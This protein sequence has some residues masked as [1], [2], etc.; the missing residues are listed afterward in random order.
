MKEYSRTAGKYLKISLLFIVSF[1]I[2]L[3]Y[4]SFFIA[5]DEADDEANSDARKNDPP[6]LEEDPWVDSVFSTMTPDQ[7]LGQLFMIAARS[8]K[9]NEYV[10]EIAETI[11]K[12]NIGGLIFMQGT[13]QRQVRHTNYYRSVAKVPLLIAMDAECGPAMRLD[14]VMKFPNQMTMG[15]ADN[16]ELVRTT[17]VEVARQLR[18]M[19]VHVNFAPV[20][21]INNNPSNPVISTRSFGENK[22]LVT[23]NGLAYIEGLQEGRI[24]AV[25]KHFPG[26]GDTDTDSHFELPVINHKW[27]R[28]EST[29]LH[30]FREA[31]KHGISGIMVAHLFVPALDSTADLPS[32]L[33]RNVVTDLLKD[34]MGFKGLIFSD[35]LNMKGVTNHFKNGEAEA[36]ALIAGCDVLLFPDDVALAIEK[37]NDAME[38]GEISRDEIDRRCRK[39]LKAKRWAGL[40]RLTNIPVE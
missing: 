17:G 7:R 22:E 8:D 4:S 34:E 28:L 25:G 16:P 19:G 18:R 39:I 38:R 40:D 35:A 36:K 32:S 2:L 9:G 10:E 15:A 3:A 12:Y 20:L 31:I 27:K 6:F 13:P 30:P 24:I 33:S 1:I 26:H 37:I 29:E 21:D 5:D 23:R 14:S 11:S